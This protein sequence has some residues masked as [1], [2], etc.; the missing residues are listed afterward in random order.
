MLAKN[1]ILKWV[2]GEI[3]MLVHYSGCYTSVDLSGNLVVILECFANILVK[4]DCYIR[5]Y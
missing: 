5:V 3:S 1:V 2:V 4:G